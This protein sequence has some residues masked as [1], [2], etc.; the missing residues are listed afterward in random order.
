MILGIAILFP[1]IDK[2]A[3]VFEWIIV[4]TNQILK[5]I[6]DLP[7]ANFSS[8]WI[9]LPA[10]ILL[11]L[12]LVFFVYALAQYN[13]KWL[14]TSLSIMIFYQSMAVFDH[15]SMI[16]QKKIIFFTLRKNYAAAFIHSNQA[17]LLTDLKQDEKTFQYFVKPALDQLQVNQ[18]SLIDIKTDTVM[19]DF[20]M[21]DHQI[22]YD[23]YKILIIDDTW[24]NKRP[25]TKGKF[26]TV[27]FTH[28]TRFKMEKLP[29][30]VEYENLIADAT[31]KD[32]KI[33]LL[34]T[35]AQNNKLQLHILKKNPAYL[36]QLTE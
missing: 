20:M 17:I 21:K 19:P 33:K 14:F 22:L 8:V 4:F 18:I 35:F 24:N 27:W 12:S 11:S 31:N 7:Y 1:L 6:A 36:V 34:K 32:Y 2:L 5:W 9:S 29:K 30:E 16:Q 3:P 15:F 23:Q 25:R 10:L 28:N 13:K 26:N